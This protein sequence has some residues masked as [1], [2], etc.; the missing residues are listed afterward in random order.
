[1][2]LAN[3]MARRIIELSDLRFL[4]IGFILMGE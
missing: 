3:N 2:T 4:I 1:M